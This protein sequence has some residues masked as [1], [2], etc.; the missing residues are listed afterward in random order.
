MLVHD[1]S[2]VTDCYQALV[3]MVTGF[4]VVADHQCVVRITV[5]QS[6]DRSG[7]FVWGCPLTGYE[8]ELWVRLQT[9]VVCW[10]WR[11]KATGEPQITVTNNNKTQHK[12]GWFRC[13]S[14]ARVNEQVITCTLWVCKHVNISHYSLWLT[15]KWYMPGTHMYLCLTQATH[16]YEVYISCI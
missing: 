13:E 5:E 12:G 4:S 9:S 16:S 14:Q 10:R 7:C 6:A 3:V 2:M 11:W 15:S 1:D 8:R